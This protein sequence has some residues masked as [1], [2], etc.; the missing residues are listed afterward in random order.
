M[1]LKKRRWT[2]GNSAINFQT[3]AGS[4]F[5]RNM[6]FSSDLEMYEL[7]IDMVKEGILDLLHMGDRRGFKW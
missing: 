1:R 5:A 2:I 7:W 3:V 6:I 4:L